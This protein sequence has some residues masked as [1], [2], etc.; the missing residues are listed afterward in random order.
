MRER[1]EKERENEKSRELQCVG[2]CFSWAP[3][4]FYFFY[5]IS[6]F[7]LI[8]FVFSNKLLKIFIVKVLIFSVG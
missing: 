2:S 5:P 6:F 7:S 8:F 1:G 4:I 3:L